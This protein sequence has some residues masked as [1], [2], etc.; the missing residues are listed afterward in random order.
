M[1]V[2]E[3]RME[4][5]KERYGLMKER[6]LEL[7]KDASFCGIYGDYVS[8]LAGFLSGV[9]EVY[10]TIEK[11]GRDGIE[12]EQ[13]VG[14][15]ERMYEDVLEPAYQHSY[16]NPD[17]AVKAFGIEMGQRL[18][19]LYTELR[20]L[21]PSAYQGN[22]QD[23]VIYSELFVEIETMLKLRG[24]SEEKSLEDLVEQVQAAI[25]AFE[26]DYSEIIVT[27]RLKSQ[28]DSSMDFALNIVMQSDFSDL[29]Y[30]YYYGDY[31][32]KN[33]LLSARYFNTLS[34][35]EMDAMAFTYTDGYREGFEIA[36]IDL[37]QKKTV[38]IRYHIGFERMV[39]AAV[40]QFAEMGLKPVLY[41]AAVKSLDKRMHLKIGY[42]SSPA[43]KQYDYDHRFDNALYLDKAF[44]E[45]KLEVLTAAYE[46]YKNLCREYAGPA[47]IET[48][49]EEEFVPVNKD[50]A[51]R[52]S[53]QQQTL[54]VKL[55]SQMG[56]LANRYIPHDQYSFT[57]IA[58]PLPEIGREYE[59]IF[60]ET[61]KVNNLDQKVYREIQQKL[62]DAL[63]EAEYVQVL[64]TGGNTTDMKVMLH[65]KQNPQKETNFEN[66]LADVNIP[67][68]EVFTSP[69]L[70]GTSGVLNVSGVFLNDL[71][72]KNLTIT[73]ENGMITDYTCS[74]FDSEEENRAFVK[75]NLLNH[76]DTLPLGEF[77]IGTNTTAYV[78]ARQYGILH[79]LPILIVE[80]MG[81]HFAVGD[82]CY[83]HSEEVRL[84]NPDGKEIVAKENECSVLRSTDEE[85]AYF[86]IH[87]D[88]T[89]PY[90]EIGL[91]AAVRPDGSQ[92]ELLRDGRFVLPGTEE[93]NLPALDALLQ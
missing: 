71:D 70:T 93:L 16:A 3:D 76:R 12:Q 72:Y 46:D 34:Q 74:N 18:C 31:I 33:E 26:R 92:I 14:W 82:T 89:I 41:P 42:A 59:A 47:C 19:F 66:C 63:D 52:L 27:E 85:K 78:M 84:F 7:Q 86:N 57:I 88:I 58:Y 30:L 25:Y 37:S 4:E 55:Q 32:G 29:S 65:Q 10:E 40:M 64:G 80:K 2:S 60:R 5:L 43:N 48:F 91:I 54:S 35:K 62:I 20:A 38:N 73:F 13:W 81:P 17:V 21:I 69:R 50:T 87:T 75:E 22:L 56:Q 15:N 28:L 11:Q 23:I 61:V 8:K 90:E 77:A 49:G 24:Q 39:K 6:I 51:I 79:K 83:S 45:R 68:G 67:V 36:G 44:A 1:D 53:A 9:Y